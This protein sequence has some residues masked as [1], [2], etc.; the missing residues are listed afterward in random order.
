[1]CPGAGAN[2]HE[3][4]R[5]V[6]ADHESATLALRVVQARRR[7]GRWVKRVGLLFVALFAVLL[8]AGLFIESTRWRLFLVGRKLRGDVREVT[9]GEL[10]HM[11]GPS[12]K[13]YLR[14][15][16]TEGRKVNGA[17][18]NPFASQADVE[19]G[20]KLYRVRCAMCHGHD[21]VG[22][23]G[24]PLN[25]P[26]YSHGNADWAVYKMVQRGI[27]GTGMPRCTILYTAQSALPCEY[28]GRL[29]GGPRSP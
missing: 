19:Q 20:S 15:M 17:I 11:L 12:S 3:S 18:Q 23:R 22:D 27:P 24:P 5:G 6:V 13:Y 26:A 25:R 29:S 8:I 10:F 21:A 9:W 7:V 14:P 16:I 4:R 2:L 28:A 1:M